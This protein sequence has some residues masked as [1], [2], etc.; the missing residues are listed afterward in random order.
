[1]KLCRFGEMGREKPGVVTLE[2]ARKDVSAHVRDFD[3]AFFAADGV[4]ELEK[5]LRAN[6][7]KCP[8]VPENV[9]WGA[10]LARPSNIVCIGLNYARHAAETG[11]E[12]PKEPVMF[13]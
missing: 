5:W 12:G 7:A 1:M 11:K 4:R 3:D 2:G 13:M 8:I 6:E 9:R 10:C